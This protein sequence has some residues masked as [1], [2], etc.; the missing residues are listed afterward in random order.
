[1]EEVHESGHAKTILSSA[2][3]EMD[4][5]LPGVVEAQL[6]AV[7]PSRGPSQASLSKS[8]RRLAP[9][10]RLLAVKQS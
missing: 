5:A 4:C 1:M 10:S 9:E 8:Y 2:G 7:V 6:R 3:S